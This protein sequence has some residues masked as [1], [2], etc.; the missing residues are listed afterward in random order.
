MHKI[1][2]IAGDGIGKEVIPAALEVIEAARRPGVLAFTELPWGCDYY[3]RNGRMMDEDG[4]EQLQKFDAI[5]PRRDR[6]SARARPHLGL[7]A[8]PAAPPAASTST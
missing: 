6:R 5:Y 1:A 3:C 8:D 2:I 7:G 4:F